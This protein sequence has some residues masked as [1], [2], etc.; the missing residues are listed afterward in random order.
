MRRICLRLLSVSLVC[1]ASGC[2]SMHN[3]TMQRVRPPIDQSAFSPSL[4]AKKFAKLMIIPPSGTAR[5]VFEPRIVLFERALL[6]RGITVISGAITGRV[7]MENPDAVAKK[8]EAAAELSD[9]ERALIMAKKTGADAILQIGDFWWSKNT[10]YTRFFV[11]EK[12]DRAPFREVDKEEYDGWKGAKKMFK[13]PEISFVSRLVDVENGEIIASF[14][15]KMPANFL[16]PRDYEATFRVPPSEGKLKRE[17]FQYERIWT[18]M[19]PT[20][21]Q[22]AFSSL[23]WWDDNEDM[24]RQVEEYVIEYV[25]R[26]ITAQ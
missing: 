6:K 14:D 2:A 19:S 24:A 9:M 25:A 22:T 8:N 3:L 7:V 16:L 21:Q 17:N 10:K 18:I 11:T 5:A 4:K 1:T 15:V 20:Q 23:P 12:T 26:I 13:S